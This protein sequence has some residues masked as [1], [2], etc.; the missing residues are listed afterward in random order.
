M[1]KREVSGDGGT[2][3]GFHLSVVILVRCH[4]CWWKLG[5]RV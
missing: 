2:E 1:T 5:L 4:Q 3:V